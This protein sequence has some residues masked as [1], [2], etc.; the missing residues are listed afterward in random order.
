M[1]E[2]IN[3]AKVTAVLLQHVEWYEVKSETLSVVSSMSFWGGDP[4]TCAFAW[5]SHGTR[6]ACPCNALLLVRYSQ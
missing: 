5:K 4:G 2:I 1:S 6:F 3:W